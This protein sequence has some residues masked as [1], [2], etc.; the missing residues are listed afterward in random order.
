MKGLKMLLFLAVRGMFVNRSYYRKVCL[1]KIYE[2]SII[3][4]CINALA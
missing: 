3:I 2:H 4:L 1:C